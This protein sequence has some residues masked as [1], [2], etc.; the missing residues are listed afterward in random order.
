MRSKS[1]SNRPDCS[2]DST[3]L[4]NKSSKYLGCWRS[5]SAK[6]LPAATSTFTSLTNWAI[7]GF[8]APSAMIS[9][10][11]MMGTPDS[12]IVASWRVKKAISS[13]LIFFARLP[14][15]VDFLLILVTRIPCFLSWFLINAAFEPWI[16]PVILV[17]FRSLPSHLNG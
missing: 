13:G 17:P 2:P 1:D 15:S 6:V 9:K 7:L 11:W 14:K 3:R 5:E 12:I 10:A 4:Q 8:S 16:S